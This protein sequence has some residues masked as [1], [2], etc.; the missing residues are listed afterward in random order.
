MKYKF[1]DDASVL[2]VI[3]LLSIGLASHNFK[4]R[5]ASNVSTHN[6]IIS[7]KHLKSQEYL[8][9]INSWSEN[10]LMELNLNKTDAMIFN[11]TKNY[12][13]TTSLELNGEKI[14]FGDETKLL[15]TVVTSDLKWERNTSEIVK[16][17]K[18]KDGYLEK[19]S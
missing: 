14:Q 12:Q 4:D 17:N 7:G 16:K 19:N 10:N 6:Q 3:N 18:C 8:E 2:E 1:I 13:F 5:I 9:K 11:F 15:G